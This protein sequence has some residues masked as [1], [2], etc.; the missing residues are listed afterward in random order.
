MKKVVYVVHLP[1]LSSPDVSNDP[2]PL[3]FCNLLFQDVILKTPSRYRRNIVS[4]GI[5]YFEKKITDTLHL[6]DSF[7]NLV[8]NVSERT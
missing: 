5:G 6:Y 1:G 3:R 7:L 2:L 8:K 4:E